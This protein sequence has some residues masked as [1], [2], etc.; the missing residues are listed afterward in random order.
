M[1]KT[2]LC[3]IPGK[4]E[5]TVDDCINCHRMCVNNPNFYASLHWDGR[6][7]RQWGGEEI[8]RCIEERRRNSGK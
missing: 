7:V 1:K 6:F 4:K 3:G 5:A 8:E 2:I